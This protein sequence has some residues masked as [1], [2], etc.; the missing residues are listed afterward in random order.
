VL[1]HVDDEVCH[2]RLSYCDGGLKPRHDRTGLVGRAGSARSGYQNYDQKDSEK[3]KT[4][5]E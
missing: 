4:D 3:D 1:A 5:D 2:F